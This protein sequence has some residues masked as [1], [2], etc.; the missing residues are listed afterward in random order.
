MIHQ[1]SDLMFAFPILVIALIIGVGLFIFWLV[2]LVNYLNT[3][4]M[5]EDRVVWALILVFLG[6]IGAFLWYLIGK[7]Q[8]T[9]KT[10]L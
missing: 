7:K 6:P 1:E 3:S 2:A 5:G 9:Q 10:A 4:N 8:Y